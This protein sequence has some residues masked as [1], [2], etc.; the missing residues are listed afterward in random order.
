MILKTAVRIYN[1]GAVRDRD[2]PI[3]FSE[4]KRSKVKVTAR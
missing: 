2:E 1:L 4:I 3:R